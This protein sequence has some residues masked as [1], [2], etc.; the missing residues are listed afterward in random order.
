MFLLSVY[1]K[2]T[3]MANNFVSKAINDGTDPQI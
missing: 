3:S 1:F 2:Y